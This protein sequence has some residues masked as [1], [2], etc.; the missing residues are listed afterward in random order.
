MKKGCF[1]SAI[2]ALTI[3]VAAVLYIIQNHLDSFIV[4][5]GKKIV[6]KFIKNELDEK[7]EVVIDSPEKTELKQMIKELSESPE[8]LK[9][10][11]EN[12]LKELMSAIDAAI[13]DSIIQKSELENISKLINQLQ[14]ERSKKN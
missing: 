3:F 14:N 13:S 1:I 5:P 6:A 12:E 9:S 10:L 11:N 4:N 8:K 7:L 2:A